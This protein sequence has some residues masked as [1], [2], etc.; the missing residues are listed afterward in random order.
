MEKAKKIWM[1]GKLVNWEDAK[2]HILTHSLHYGSAIFEGIRCYETT[3]GPAVFRLKDHVKRLFN[4]AKIYSMEIPYTPKEIYDAVKQTV[5]VNGLKECYI[6]PIS[7]YGYGELKL[8]SLQSKVGV[9]I[10]AFPFT[11]FLGKKKQVDGVRCK[12]SSWIRITSSIM[13]P[14][15]KA[16]GNYANSLLADL[17]ARKA[18]YDEAIFENINGYI[19]EG[20]GENI[21]L[22]RD[23]KIITPAPSAGVLCGITRDSVMKI[24]RDMGYEVTER[25]IPREEVF[26]SDEAFFTGTAAEI[27]PIV[28]VDNRKVGNGKRGPITEKIQK[29]FFKIVKGEDRDYSEWLDFIK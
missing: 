10:A 15:A 16:A 27:T 9:A 11:S 5:K 14:Q 29:K 8:D 2:V 12:I 7:Y 21:F 18:G 26:I 23:G 24:A 28:E 25:D 3:G 13:P 1:D 20:P 17:E 6:R 19:A 22:V 4:S